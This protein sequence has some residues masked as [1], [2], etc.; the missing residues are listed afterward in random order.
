MSDYAR[1]RN[2]LYPLNENTL[3]N[4]KS[5]SKKVIH[6]IGHLNSVWKPILPEHILLTTMHALVGHVCDQINQEI[7]KLSDIGVDESHWLHTGL[8][9]WSSLETMFKV[10]T[11][12]PKAFRAFMSIRSILNWSLAEIESHYKN[13]QLHLE[14]AFIRRMIKALFSDTPQRN[15]LLDELR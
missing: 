3:Q 13:G 1:E 12:I 2:G 10:E 11:Y 9:V 4:L 6:H 8:E 7:L 15:R 5:S 14:A